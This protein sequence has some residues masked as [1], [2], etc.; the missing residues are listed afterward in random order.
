MGSARFSRST[1]R[2]VT[3]SKVEGGSVSARPLYILTSVNVRARVT[4]RRNTA[5]FWWDSI[6]VRTI[7]GAQSFIGSPGKPAPEPKS[8]TLV[9]LVR[10]SVAGTKPF[11][12]EGTGDTEETLGKRWRATNRDSP[13][14]RGTISSGSRIAVRLMRAF[15]RTSIS[16]YVDI[17]SYNEPLSLNGVL[18]ASSRKRRSSSAIRGGRMDCRL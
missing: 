6:R 12:T 3:T 4:S 16:M 17:R 2:M 15:Q 11:T 18:L 10:R 8:A 13:K 1:A 14:W 5:F 9:L 7:S